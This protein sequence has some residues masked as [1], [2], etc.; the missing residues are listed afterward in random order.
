M[1]EVLDGWLEGYVQA[2]MVAGVCVLCLRFVREENCI[3]GV[4]LLPF[5]C[6]ILAA[7]PLL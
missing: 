3:T 1:W 6:W 5:V 4:L 7:A 2:V